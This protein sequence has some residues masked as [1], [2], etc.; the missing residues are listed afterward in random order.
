L[1]GDVTR[2]GLLVELHAELHVVDVADAIA[3][4]TAEIRSRSTL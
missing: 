2:H 1:A 3:Y 4:V